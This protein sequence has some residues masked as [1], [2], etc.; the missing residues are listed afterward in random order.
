MP[1]AAY[2]NP[3]AY[4]D[5]TGINKWVWILSHVFA[6]T[7]FMSLFSLLFGAGIILLTEKLVSTD[8]P[9]RRIW[10]SRIIWLLLFGLAHAFLLWPGDILVMYAICGF[11][12]FFFRKRSPKFLIRLAVAFFI[13]PVLINMFQ[14]LSWDFIPDDAKEGI[15]ESWRPTSEANNQTVKILSEG[16]YSERLS[17][18]IEEYIG[19]FIYY[20]LFTG[21]W[22]IMAMMLFGMYFYKKGALSAE[23]SVDTYKKII[24]IYLPLALI[25]ICA[26]VWYNFDKGWTAQH[27]M[28]LGINFNYVGSL[29]MAITY[30]SAVM[31]WSK[32]SFLKGWQVLIQKT[33]KMAFTNYI[34]MSVICTTFFYRLGTF[35]NFSRLYQLLFTFVVWAIILVFT[36]AWMKNFKMGPLEWLWRTLTYWKKANIR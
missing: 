18:R 21:I 9:V 8:R 15:M 4:G 6:D 27:S 10:Y 36:E 30:L 19:I 35:G 31:L 16:S 14:G 12:T 13:I 34:L 33:G 7:K 17:L 25:I 28:F 3:S 5:L 11:I 22:R 29:F 26:G 20:F 23:W 32:S 1:S 24:K 2:I